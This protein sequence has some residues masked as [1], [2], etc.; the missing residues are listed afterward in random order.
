MKSLILFDKIIN[1]MPDSQYQPHAHYMGGT[2]HARLLQYAQSVAYYQKVVDH[3]PTFE[4]AGS[5]QSL[6]G[7]YTLAM[8][9]IGELTPEQANPQAP[10]KERPGTK[11]K[12]CI[13]YYQGDRLL[14]I[15][16]LQKVA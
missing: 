10:L 1:E 7:S 9:E 14:P 12:L 5:A 13:S 3:W 4:F 11:M 15:V 2:C 8:R 6:V 16:D